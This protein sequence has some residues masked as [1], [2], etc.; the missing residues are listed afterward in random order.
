MDEEKNE[1]M[2][3]E[4]NKD[5]IINYITVLNVLSAIAVVILH[6]KFNIS[7]F[8]N[9][10]YWQNAN[11]IESIFHFAVPVFFM[12]SGIMLID[13]RDRYNTKTF[14]E[15]R[16]KKTVIPFIFWSIIGILYFSFV[17]KKFKISDFTIT[18]F[19]NA[20]MGTKY[21]FVYW[22]FPALFSVYLCIPLFSAIEKRLRKN[23]FIY[24]LIVCA[25]FNFILPFINK[26]YVYIY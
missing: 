9:E 26:V 12:I 6:S 7:I 18:Q 22:F 21:M 3:V 14:F 10:Q 19:L 20:I 8:S 24:L 17:R 13:Y 16:I 5:K 25:I 23:V 15:K 11:I 1:L 4:K 2:I